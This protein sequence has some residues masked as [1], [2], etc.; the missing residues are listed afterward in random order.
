MCLC[1]CTCEEAGGPEALAL[2]AHHN[3]WSGNE[4]GWAFE[5]VRLLRCLVVLVL[6]R[7]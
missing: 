6:N 2:T 4:E 3:V 7:Q 5:A 1:A